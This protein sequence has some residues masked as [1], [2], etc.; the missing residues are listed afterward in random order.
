MANLPPRADLQQER[1][2]TIVLD[3]VSNE[4]LTCGEHEGAPITAS[5][6]A[7]VI[8]PLV[9]WNSSVMSCGAPCDVAV[10]DRS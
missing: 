1:P 8:T 3:M 2:T 10:E 7:P 9:C 6:V 5:A 4:R